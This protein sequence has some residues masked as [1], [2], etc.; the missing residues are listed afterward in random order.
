MIETKT[1][2]TEGCGRPVHAKGFCEKCYMADRRPR[3]VQQMEGPDL[4]TVKI[5]IPKSV[6]DALVRAADK[7][8]KTVSRFVAELLG[9]V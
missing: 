7:D 4:V 3:G 6:R 5:K 2:K 9:A 1:C 8:N